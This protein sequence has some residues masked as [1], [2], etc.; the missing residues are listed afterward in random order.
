MTC[1][2]ASFAKVTYGV[3]RHSTGAKFADAEVSDA[4]ASGTN[5]VHPV[6]QSTPICLCSERVI[7]IMLPWYLNHLICQ[8]ENP[9]EGPFC[10]TG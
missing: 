10:S 5:C 2:T 4:T 7:Q 3:G 8:Q 6:E 9:H 1:V